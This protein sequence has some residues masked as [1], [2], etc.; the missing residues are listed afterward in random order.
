MIC[1]LIMFIDIAILYL[2]LLIFCGAAIQHTGFV[3]CL[4]REQEI[5]EFPPASDRL[6]IAQSNLVFGPF[7]D[8]P[9]PLY[10]NMCCHCVVI[11]LSLCCHCVVIELIS[12]YRSSTRL[13]LCMAIYHNIEISP[14]YDLCL[15]MRQR[16]T[17]LMLCLWV[18]QLCSI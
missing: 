16:V 4:R 6:H 1:D 5:V 12:A 10:V 17:I 18:P 15:Y 13:S 9:G 8:I 2:N 11:V 3:M 14:L 7:M